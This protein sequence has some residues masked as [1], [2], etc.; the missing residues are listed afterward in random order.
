VDE[1]PIEGV[2]GALDSSTYKRHVRIRARPLTVCTTCGQE[3]NRL[4]EGGVELKICQGC[5]D[6]AFCSKEC[7]I[8]YWPRHKK[9]CGPLEIG[10]ILNEYTSR[11]LSHPFLLHHLRVAL[12]PKLVL[13]R[14]ATSMKFDPQECYHIVVYLNFHPTSSE[15]E[16]GLILGKIDPKGKDKIPGF[17]RLEILDDPLKPVPIGKRRLTRQREND[18]MLIRLWRLARKHANSIGHQRYPIVMVGFGYENIRHDYGI[19]ITPE[20][21]ATALS[22]VAS[23][24]PSI[25][26]PPFPWTY[27]A[28]MFL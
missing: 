11:F 12:I 17:L 15:H 24:P 6:A 14:P 28:V 27:D 13:G 5:L 18:T 21:F 25:K 16:V 10:R 20:A 7:Q 19:E 3:S 2:Y 4:N 9:E 23:L 26:P 8:A 1:K 22:P